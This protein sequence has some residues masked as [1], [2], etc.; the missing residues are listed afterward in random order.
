MCI[1]NIN[2]HFWRCCRGERR[3]AELTL[4][5]ALPCIHIFYLFILFIPYLFF[6]FILPFSILMDD[7]NSIP[8]YQFAAPMET[9]LIPWES[10]QPIQ[11]P[12]Y[13]LSPWLIAM[14]QSL[15]FLGKEDNNPYLHIRDI[16]QTCDCLRIEG[17]FDKTL[18]WKLF[19]FSLKGKLDNGIIKL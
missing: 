14:V 19:P 6:S 18:R 13:R 3:S 2:K 10:S 1:I 11:T 15:S 9:S 8:I 17:I 4:S 7:I 5:L 12:N 16:E